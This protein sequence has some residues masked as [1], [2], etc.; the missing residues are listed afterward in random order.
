[1]KRWRALALRVTIVL[2]LTISIFGIQSTQS[3]ASPTGFGDPTTVKGMTGFQMPEGTIAT[4][5]SVYQGREATLTIDNDDSTYWT[6]SGY[7]AH[8]E[9]RFPKAL[10]LDYVQVMSAPLNPSNS[11]YT[12]YGIVNGAIVSEPIGSYTTYNDNGVIAPP[13][14]ITHG[15][16]DGIAVRAVMDK[17]WVGIHE[18]TIWNNQNITLAASGG[19]TTATLTWNAIENAESY[20]IKYGTESSVYTETVTATKD[21]YSN[22]VIPGLTNGTTY[23]FVVRATV[24]GVASDYSNEASATPNATTPTPEQP[25]GDRAILVVT[26]TTGLEKEFD[27][28]MSE[29]NAFIAWYENKQ[30]GS[31][32]ASYAIDKH[33]NN[34]GPFTN[35]KDYMIFDKILTFSV[36]EYSAE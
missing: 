9:L 7:D 27:L 10:L 35:R 6:G 17:S 13:I 28:T 33:D 16:Y 29:V 26:M 14:K 36:D 32:T 21:E 22:Y 12:I 23:F 30:S 1:M 2:C 31:G 15:S 25:T 4:A 19:N 34:K 5:T 20:T 24:N 8:V 18:I 3:F 11:T